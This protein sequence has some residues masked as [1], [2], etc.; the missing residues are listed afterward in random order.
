M[1]SDPL[2]A[3]TPVVAVKGQSPDHLDEGA[4]N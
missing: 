4:K 2:G 1:N 3:R